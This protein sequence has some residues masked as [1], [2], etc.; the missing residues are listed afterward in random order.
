MSKGFRDLIVWQRAMDL[1]VK[2]YKLTGS[3]PASQ[4][5]SLA[6]QLQR[7]AASVPANIAEG[8]GRVHTGDYLRHLAIARGSLAEA[9]TFVEL[10]ARLEFCEAD[11]ARELWNEIQQ[12]GRMLNSLMKKIREGDARKPQPEKQDKPS[13]KTSS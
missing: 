6:D 5:Y 4:R 1:A 3:F 13:R 11:R 10:A 12:L 9:D 8:K 7:A 2:A